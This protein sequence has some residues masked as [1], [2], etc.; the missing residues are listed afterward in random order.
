MSGLPMNGPGHYAEAERLAEWVEREVLFGHTELA[1]VYAA[2]AQVHATL[3]LTAATVH[4]IRTE[5]AQT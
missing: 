2:L 3:S 4:V 1:G 5:S